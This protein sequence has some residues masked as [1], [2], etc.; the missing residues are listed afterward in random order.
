MAIKF[1][2]IILFFALL[3]VSSADDINEQI[4]AIKAAKGHERVEMMNRL[5]T[6]IAAMN[7]NERSEALQMLQGN[8][9]HAKN[10]SQNH[11]QHRMNQDGFNNTRQTQPKNIHAPQQNN[12]GAK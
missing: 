11:L 4:E 12:Q 10:R 9:Q 3:S 2:L 6:Q 8:M 5:K 7:E 1:Y